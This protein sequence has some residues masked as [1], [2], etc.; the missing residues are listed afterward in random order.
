V[1]IY[2]FWRVVPLLDKDHKKEYALLAG[3]R[4]NTETISGPIAKQPSI[5]IIEKLMEAG[6]SVGS[7]PRIYS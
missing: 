3:G 5:T 6:F 2:V 1:L 4:L 7:A